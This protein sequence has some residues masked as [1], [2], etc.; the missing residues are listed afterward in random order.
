MWRHSDVSIM[1]VAHGYEGQMFIV[2]GA[3]SG[4]GL[5]TAIVLASRGFDVFAVGRNLDSL[6]TLRGHFPERVRFISADISTTAG[7]DAIIGATSSITCIDGIVHAAGS[8]VPL[9]AYQDLSIQENELEQHF[10]V[11]VTAPIALNNRL[12]GKLSGSRILY[13]DSNSANSLRVGWAGYSIVKAAAQM[14]ARSAMAELNRSTV[15]RLFP[16]GVRT[17][18]VDAVLASTDQSEAV[19][20]FRKLDRDGELSTA[21]AVGAYIVHLLVD[22]SESQ[23]ASRDYWDFQN[24]S[25]RIF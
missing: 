1:V 13:I 24:R 6:Q 14:A 10:S 17:P 11:H 8:S 7:I 18:L 3:S 2:T 20:I 19:A 16:G 22:A 4:I 23:L 12:A 9:A 15:I 25:D 21:E 5:A